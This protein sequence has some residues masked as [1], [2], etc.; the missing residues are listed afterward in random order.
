MN[1]CSHSSGSL[2][3]SCCKVRVKW[4][5]MYRETRRFSQRRTRVSFLCS[6]GTA[7]GFSPMVPDQH[8]QNS[9]RRQQQRPQGSQ[10][11]R[12][13]IGQQ[14]QRVPSG[15]FG[16]PALRGIHGPL[17]LQIGGQGIPGLQLRTVRA[18]TMRLSK[19]VTGAPFSSWGVTVS[20]P[21]LCASTAPSI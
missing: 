6:L 18:F 20:R 8:H 21:M 16:L 10:C 12:A 7:A 9:Q 1:R 17:L 4:G 11:G 19:S 2:V 15:G 5:I 13:G 3:S 14:R